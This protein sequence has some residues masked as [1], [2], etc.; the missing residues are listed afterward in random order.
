MI[1][2]SSRR[3]LSAGALI[4]MLVLSACGTDATATP[5]PAPTNTAAATGTTPTTGAATGTTPST[6]PAAPTPTAVAVGD[7]NAKLLING[8]GAT[9]P[10]PIYT[11]WF[12]TYVSVDPT[13]RFNYQPIGSGAGIQQITARTVDFGA[14]D[15]PLTDAQIQAA[16]KAGGDIYHVPT[17]AG[18]EPIIY[19]LPGVPSGLKLDGDT[20]AKIYLGTITSWDDP[21]IK[22]Q[23]AEMADKLTGDIAVVHRSDGS[24]TTNIFTDY[25]SSAS[26][27]WKSKVGKGT[28][29]N[30][31]VGLGG[32]GNAGVAGLVQ[33]TPGGIGYV[34]LA[35]AKQNKLPYALVKNG[36]GEYIEPTLDSTVAA[37]ES[38][39]TV[40][41]DLRVS[42]VNSSKT[43]SYPIA[44]FTYILIYKTQTDAAKGTGLA[45][46][47]WWAIHD[48]EAQAQTLDY[49]PLPAS[50]VTLAETKIKA[51]DCG[52]S[53]CYK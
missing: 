38:L 1:S 44:G 26:P 12:Q 46:F 29:V 39:T 34:E 42:I 37:T 36:S 24:G 22:S 28:S 50:V 7:P 48:G 6:A 10:A 18:A 11:K 13:V 25:L 47:L 23:N 33:Q 27:D 9:F 40:P 35:Y 21:A 8:A 32:R 43:G 51:L 30:W 52:G 3:W 15:A 31:P 17:V 20:L 16:Q 2:L 49:A 19:N 4:S 53:P 14:S 5:P 41:D 45:K